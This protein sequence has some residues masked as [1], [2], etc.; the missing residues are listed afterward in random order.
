MEL[1]HLYTLS[2]MIN[3]KI[4]KGDFPKE[5]EDNIEITVKLDPI[6]FYGIDREFYYL[7]HGNSYKGF[8][9]KNIVKAVVNGVNFNLLPKNDEKKEEK[10]G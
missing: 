7:T 2:E 4:D 8:Q 9:H 6:T 1:R 10:N 5:I 3:E